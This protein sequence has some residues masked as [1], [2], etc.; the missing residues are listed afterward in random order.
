MRGLKQFALGVLNGFASRT[1]TGAWIETSW[2]SPASVIRAVAPSRVRGLKLI[3]LHRSD[4]RGRRRTFTGAWIETRRWSTPSTLGAGV[5]PSRVRGL[6]LDGFA[7][8]AVIVLVAP[9]RVRGLKLGYVPALRALGGRTFTG[10][11]IETA[12]SPRST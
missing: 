8:A 3:G 12:T 6:K 1:F 7:P 9:S 11:W 10:A 2:V 4:D 5:A